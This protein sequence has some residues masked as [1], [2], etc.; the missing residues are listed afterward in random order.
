MENG[1]NL[2][3]K[4]HATP[5]GLWNQTMWV[6]NPDLSFHS[7]IKFGRF[8]DSSLGFLIYVMRVPKVSVT[9]KKLRSLAMIPQ[10][11]RNR[12]GM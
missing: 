5:S 9:S 7:D 11:V 1:D 4:Q 2:M 10:F 12:A 8:L 6:S 3:E